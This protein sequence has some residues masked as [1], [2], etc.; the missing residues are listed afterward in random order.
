MFLDGPGGELRD[1]VRVIFAGER[2][3]KEYS[4][5][6]PAVTDTAQ[7][8]TFRVLGFESLVK[9]K[10][11]SFRDKDRTHLRDMIE[12]GLLDPTWPARFQPELRARLQELLDD[13]EG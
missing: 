6:A 9:M 11:T 2:V 4:E 12:V 1:A 3:R 10:L 5:P 7:H 8:E 13:P